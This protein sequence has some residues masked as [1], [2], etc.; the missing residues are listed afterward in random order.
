MSSIAGLA[1]IATRGHPDHPLVL[2]E[3]FS[4]RAISHQSSRCP[5]L[6]L[7]KIGQKHHYSIKMERHFNEMMVF[8][9][10]KNARPIIT[11]NKKKPFT[12]R[13]FIAVDPSYAKA[14]EG[15]AWTACPPWAG[16]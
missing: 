6:Y 9:R 4:M 15:Q 8:C 11:P 3:P 14:S 7:V 13:F 12:E 5:L 16:R 2:F 1:R 10:K